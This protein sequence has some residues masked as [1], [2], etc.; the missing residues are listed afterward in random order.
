MPPEERRAGR[1]KLTRQ[2]F[3]PL[4]GA[5]WYVAPQW[6]ETMGEQVE[7]PVGEIGGRVEGAV[8]GERMAGLR[9]AESRVQARGGMG[10]VCSRLPS[11]QKIVNKRA[12]RCLFWSLYNGQQA[13]S[14]VRFGGYARREIGIR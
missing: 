4:G 12:E 6:I 11:A 9:G 8:A 3:L 14:S 5:A 13:D 7:A 10:V 1:G 2:R